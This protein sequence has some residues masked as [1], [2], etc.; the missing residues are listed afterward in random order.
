MPCSLQSNG[1]PQAQLQQLKASLGNAKTAFVTAT[2]NAPA[3]IKRIPWFKTLDEKVL[4]LLQPKPEADAGDNTCPATCLDLKLI[5]GA[6]IYF[7][8]F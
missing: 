7:S 4:P 1:E 6:P 3:V 2:N 5:A 8:I